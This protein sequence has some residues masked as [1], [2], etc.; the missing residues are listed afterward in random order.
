MW[1][2]AHTISASQTVHAGQHIRK[3]PIMPEVILGIDLGTT[4]SCVA[5]VN[6]NGDLVRIQIGNEPFLPS[7]VRIVN[8]EIEVG[9]SAMNQWGID[10]DRVVRW[11]KRSMGDPSFLHPDAELFELP[12]D[13]ANSLT[14]AYQSEEAGK[15][16]VMEIPA[17]LC[18]AFAAKKAELD[19]KATLYE[20][21]EGRS[22]NLVH[23]R[24]TGGYCIRKDHATGRWNVLQGW[25]AVAVSAEIL[26]E[27]KRYAQNQLGNDIIVKKAVITCP[28][29][30]NSNEVEA[31]KAAGLRAGFEVQEIIKEPVAAGI[32]HAM[33]HRLLGGQRMLVCDLGGGTFDATILKI[34]EDG[35]FEPV[36]TKGNRRLGGHD[37]TDSLKGWMAKEYQRLYG[38][39]LTLDAQTDQ[40]LYQ[41]AETVKRNLS[42]MKQVTAALQGKK[43]MGS[44]V[45][46]REKMDELTGGQIR[47]IDEKLEAVLAE[48]MSQDGNNKDR[49]GGWQDIH[50]VLLVGGSS[51]LLAFQADVATKTGKKPEIADEPDMAVAYG[52][53][54]LAAGRFRRSVS[55]D[56][57]EGGLVKAGGE[58]SGGGLFK[59]RLVR[60]TPRRLGTRAYDL[61]RGKIMSTEIIPQGTAIPVERRNDQFLAPSGDCVDIPV[62]E[63]ENEESDEYEPIKSY[64]CVLGDGVTMGDQLGVQFNYDVSGI[65]S[66]AAYHVKT[67]RPLPVEPFDY[68]EPGKSQG[69]HGGQG[70]RK[71]W[72]V[73]FALDISWSMEGDELRNAKEALVNSVR[74]VL[75]TSGTKA[76]VVL[77]GSDATVLCSPTNDAEGIVAKIKTV[78]CNGSTNM[79]GALAHCRNLLES[80]PDSVDKEIALLTDGMP[81]SSPETLA[82]ARRVTQAG[83]KLSA[84]AIGGSVDTNFLREMTPTV[85]VVL[86]PRDIDD[87]L[88][89]IL[90]RK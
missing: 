27:L 70:R 40:R 49:I 31:T 56:G 25:S 84:L 11:I 33:T 44:V 67:N 73:L 16:N 1:G 46:T 43:S 66:V 63:F 53:A 62:V 74:R 50:T 61:D 9:Q 60:T 82:E 80:E 86:N 76:G 29:Y 38:E 34:H 6:E 2:K 8:A 15:R 7:V 85:V 87:G 72:T 81:D 14:L 35:S 48:A 75:S 52:A 12:D 79:S 28:A 71:P 13:W 23:E 4:F 77:F 78:E 68:R 30:F 88:D 24:G 10:E 45:V 26:K 59:P 41:D 36:H 21:G 42:S 37:W 18:E 57:D 54:V 51:R 69:G 39:D 17:A 89:G 19:S 47:Q 3:G 32:Y 65:I 90:T 55:S 5:Y 64:R 83:I 22:Y 58:D 20:I